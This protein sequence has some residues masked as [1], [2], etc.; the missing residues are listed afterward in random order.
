MQ[1]E[2]LRIISANLHG[3][4]STTS[5][6]FKLGIKKTFENDGSRAQAIMMSETMS[7]GKLTIQDSHSA[8]VVKGS[9]PGT[10]MCMS[11]NPDG[12]PSHKVQ[13]ISPRLQLLTIFGLINIISLYAPQVAAPDQTKENFR[14]S[15]A[16]LI[17]KIDEANDE[18][19]LLVGDFNID[20]SAIL[21]DRSYLRDI[22]K[23]G[24]IIGNQQPTQKHGKELDYGILLKPNPA[25]K[26]SSAVLENATSD[27]DAVAIQIDNL[28]L[29]FE[30]DD[31]MIRQKPQKA[32]PIPRTPKA[33]LQYSKSVKAAWGKFLSN[34]RAIRALLDKAE[35]VKEICSCRRGSSIDHTKLLDE[36]YSELRKIIINQATKAARKPDTQRKKRLPA[37]KFERLYGRFKRK[38]IGKSRFQKLLRWKINEQ[39]QKDYEGVIG[40]IGNSKQFYTKIRRLMGQNVKKREPKIPVA[41][42]T[43]IYREIYEP[44]EFTKKE[45]L[46]L[47]SEMKKAENPQEKIL[48]KF[49]LQ[50]ISSSMKK[51]KLNKA[52]RGPKIEH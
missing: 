50:E 21:D 40:K 39:N 22:A 28:N 7:D 48:T 11:I 46:K 47:K 2:T 31:E 15:T 8:H 5:Q 37:G 34:N 29:T 9:K 13:E 49:T 25:F 32:P 30:E 20:R 3:C 43:R 19:I 45:V 4:S 33:I 41:G 23:N 18:P 17:K 27:H 38:E 26:I 10:G 12:L 14:K 52:S 51:V 35:T 6:R 1:L 24:V 36:A 42:V 16:K 44:E